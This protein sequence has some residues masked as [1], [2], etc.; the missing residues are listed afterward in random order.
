MV[1]VLPLLPGQVIGAAVASVVA[2]AVPLV[3]AAEGSGSDATSL[4]DQTCAAAPPSLSV[5]FL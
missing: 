2:V 3:V 5:P 4:A 1:G